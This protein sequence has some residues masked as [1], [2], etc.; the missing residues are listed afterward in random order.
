M[1]L[2]IFGALLCL[3]S[4]IICVRAAQP[5]AELFP[6]PVPPEDLERLDQ[7]C[8]FLVHNFWKR[9]E[10]KTAFS[11][12]D[13]L[14]KAFGDWIGFMPYAS[15]DTV[16]MAIDDLLKRVE[17][18]GPQ[19][20]KMASMAEAWMYGDTAS[21]VSEELY[22]PFARAAANNK[23]I[24]AAERMRFASQVKIIESSGIGA[25]FPDITLTRP[26]GSRF[27]MSEIT[28][29]HILVFINDPDCDNCTM[30]RLRLS[31]D[32]GTGRLIDAG[33][34][35][36]VSIYPDSPKDSEWLDKVSAYPENWM[37]GACEDIDSYVDLSQMPTYLYLDGDHIV[38]VKN[39]ELDNILRAF[40]QLYYSLQ[41]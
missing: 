22:L 39:M 3:L 33:Q 15:A 2:R 23:K 7:R 18:N 26:D 32:H 4:N 5:T 11:S 1:K 14:N 8:N 27:S 16:H 19:T 24:P 21:Y 20:L 29:P 31:I 13:R 30:A 40:N 6:Y 34:L 38:R 9:C 12:M 17:K 28:A 10:F 41:Q 37:V 36:I 25:K 35:T